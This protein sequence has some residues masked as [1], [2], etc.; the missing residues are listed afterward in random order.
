[1][2]AD[3]VTTPGNL[4]LCC[5]A[6][7]KPAV[8]QVDFALQS[9]VRV[10]GNRLLSSNPL[11]GFFSAL[12]SAVP[13]VAGSLARITRARTSDDGQFVVVEDPHPGFAAQIRP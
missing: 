5:T 4:P 9:R 1:M 8:R 12:V 10:E 3:P 2:P 13:F 7:G 6:H 11:G